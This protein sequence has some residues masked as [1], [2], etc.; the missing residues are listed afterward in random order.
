MSEKLRKAVKVSHQV[1]SKTKGSLTSGGGSLISGGGPKIGADSMKGSI[2]SGA[3]SL[4]SGVG[5]KGGADSVFKKSSLISEASSLTSGADSN[6]SEDEDSGSLISGAGWISG[7]K[8]SF[9]SRKVSAFVDQQEILK[10][11]GANSQT[12]T[13]KS[14]KFKSKAH[15]KTL[16]LEDLDPF[17]GEFQKC[18]NSSGEVVEIEDGEVEGSAEIQAEPPAEKIRGDPRMDAAEF[19]ANISDSVWKKRHVKSQLQKLILSRTANCKLPMMEDGDDLGDVLARIGVQI[20]SV[21]LK[22]PMKEIIEGRK[23]DSCKKWF[24]SN[25]NWI[26]QAEED[27][28]L[29]AKV[30]WVKLHKEAGLVLRP[31][32]IGESSWKQSWIA[33]FVGG[34]TGMRA[35]MTPSKTSTLSSTRSRSRRNLLK[36]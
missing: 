20:K 12:D 19:A 6:I 34:N 28:I 18:P 2:T 10:A 7:E 30:S 21:M 23:K 9:D 31:F 35:R 3:G 33:L 17:S 27:V 36:R 13:S 11:P 22:L 26:E 24:Y 32:P 16:P 25:R 15:A 29:N 4:I 14:K 5:N 1:V 8:D